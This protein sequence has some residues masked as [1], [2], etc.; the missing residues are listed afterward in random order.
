MLD[1]KKLLNDLN[2]IQIKLQESRAFVLPKEEILQLENSRKNLQQ[3]LQEMQAERNKTSKDIG[4]LKRTQQDSSQLELR[5]KNLNVDL[6]TTEKQLEEVSNK[7]HDIY[8]TIPNLPLDDVPYG[9]SEDDNVVIRTVGEVKKFTFTPKDHVALGEKLS[10]MDFATASKLSGS[11]FVVLSQDLA[12]MHRALIQFMLS[13]HIQA[14]YKEMYVPYLVK[15]ECFYGTGQ[16]PKFGKD[17]FKVKDY[18]LNLISTAEISL[19]NLFRNTN[20]KDTELPI[21]L[22]AHTPCFRSEAGSYGKDTRGMIRQHQFEKVEL[23]QL[24]KPEDSYKQHEELT[25]QAAGILDKLELAYRVVVLATG[26]LGF[27]AAKTYDLEVWLPSQNCY[28]EISSCSNFLDF[29]AR[30]MQAKW[31]NP[32]TK[33]NEFLHTVNGSGLAVGRTLVAVMENYQDETGNIHIPKVLQPYMQN[34]TVIKVVED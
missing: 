4:I 5:V 30:R 29:Q 6:K 15:K 24:V 11:R 27:S 22:T 9:T 18:D 16:L 14:G 23:V 17:F 8:S 31:R 28:R 2:N 26:D 20:V 10:Q 12:A 33:K 25:S 32:E 34:R 19:T 3:S 21:K 7:L 13:E 1:K